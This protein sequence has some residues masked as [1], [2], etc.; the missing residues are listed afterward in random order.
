MMVASIFSPVCGII[1][2]HTIYSVRY[3]A[4]F[5]LWLISFLKIFTTVS[6]QELFQK[7]Y[8]RIKITSCYFKRL[9]RKNN[10]CAHFKRSL[11]LLTLYQG[12][13]KGRA[14]GACTAGQPSPAQA[15]SSNKS[16]NKVSFTQRPFLEMLPR[17]DGSLGEGAESYLSALEPAQWGTPPSGAAVGRDL[18]CQLSSYKHC[19]QESA[20]T[21]ALGFLFCDLSLTA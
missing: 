1:W 16:I 15:S 4:T 21:S 6:D 13:W 9:K 14:P 5:R 17:N 8:L 11:F 18:S 2:G 20:I 3:F 12:A 19:S 7:M 10:S